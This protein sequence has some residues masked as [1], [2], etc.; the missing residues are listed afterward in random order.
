[1]DTSIATAKA[2]A[3][4]PTLYAQSDILERGKFSKS[5][6]Y[7]MMARGHFPKPSLVLGPRFTRWN[8]D[9]DRWF[10]NPLAWIDSHAE[11]T[12]LTCDHNVAGEQ[13]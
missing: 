2:A 7:N 12:Q 4:T 11:A 8:E 6:L 10:E 1:M 9:V 5:H 3:R 13:S